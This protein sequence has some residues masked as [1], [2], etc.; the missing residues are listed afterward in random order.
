MY[1]ASIATDEEKIFVMA[2]SSPGHDDLYRVLCYDSKTDRWDE[3][4][5]PGHYWGILH[6]IDGRLTII[7]GSESFDNQP[8]PT[9]KVLAYDEDGHSW[10]T[11]YPNMMNSRCKPGVITHLDYVIA[12][13]GESL[14]GQVRDDIEILNWKE[15]TQWM[16]VNVHLPQRMWAVSVTISDCDL[17][18]LG[19]SGVD[20]RYSTAY[21]APVDLIISSASFQ[22]PFIDNP[23]TEITPV[24]YWHATVIPNLCSPTIVGGCDSA[25][26]NCTAQI[27]MLD[28]SNNTW[29]IIGYLSTARCGIGI[30]LINADTIIVIGGSTKPNSID[31]ALDYSSD[32][33]ERGQVMQGPRS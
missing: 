1:G 31:S 20:W 12:I 27:H 29:K 9:N 19:Y 21:Q 3:L 13:G 26:E 23:F 25:G 14:N 24:P 16:M 22:P 6:I 28:V 11:V 33:V 32:V 10:T 18:I 30:A 4:P 5:R 15:P 7:G 8:I 17:Y 2:G